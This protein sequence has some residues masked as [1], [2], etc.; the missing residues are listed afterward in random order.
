MK[1]RADTARRYREIFPRMLTAIDRA[2][3]ILPLDEVVNVW[4]RDM[5]SLALEEEVITRA[6]LTKKDPP[7]KRAAV[8]TKTW[9]K[10]KPEWL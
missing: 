9:N 3:G 8:Y 1:I 7:V 4:G 2:G 5:V 10:E 6:N